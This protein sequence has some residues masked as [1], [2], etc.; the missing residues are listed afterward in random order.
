MR[1]VFTPGN[2]SDL[3]P[4]R[5]MMNKLKGWDRGY[6][7]KKLQQQLQFQGIELI[8]KLKKNMKK[9]I[10]DPAKEFIVNKRNFVE[11]A[12]GQLKIGRAS[13][14]ERV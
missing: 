13:C 8:T 4:V 11:T 1:F 12:S 7:S 3:S 9:Y 10:L 6:I 14:R 2:T 5:Q